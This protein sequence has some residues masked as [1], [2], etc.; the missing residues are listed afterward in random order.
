MSGSS[1]L[2]SV[3]IW[4]KVERLEHKPDLAIANGRELVVIHFGNVFPLNS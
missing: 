4:Q 2:R 1:T 3:S